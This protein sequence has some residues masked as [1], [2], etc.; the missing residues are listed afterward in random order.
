MENYVITG[1]LVGLF[2]GIIGL[3]VKAKK[4]G[5]KCI[6]CPHAKECGNKNN[7]DSKCNK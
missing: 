6:G 5:D 1:I 2:S 4:R 3:I 7:P